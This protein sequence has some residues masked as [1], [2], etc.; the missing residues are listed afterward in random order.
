MITLVAVASDLPPAAAQFQVDRAVML[1]LS[2]MPANGSESLE[3]HISIATKST[4]P[5]RCSVRHPSLRGW[6]ET[7][8]FW[9]FFDHRFRPLLH[10]SAAGV[11]GHR[12]SSVIFERHNSPRIQLR[13][14]ITIYCI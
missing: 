1:N 11:Q 5:E 7:D 10:I 14:H 9:I 8:F 13:Q 4:A 3:I 12:H 2:A 6:G